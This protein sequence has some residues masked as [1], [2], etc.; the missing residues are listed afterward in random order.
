MPTETTHI[1]LSYPR[2]NVHYTPL[3]EGRL[4]YDGANCNDVG[5]LSQYW[6]RK[7]PRRGRLAQP[8]FMSRK[9]ANESG[10]RC[11]RA[12]DIPIRVGAS[13]MKDIEVQ[14]VCRVEPP[15]YTTVPS[16][17]TSAWNRGAVSWQPERCGSSGSREAARAPGAA[18]PC[19][20]H[21]AG[22]LVLQLL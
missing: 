18:R 5:A 21:P 13:I 14:L 11:K 6:E 17:S 7:A 12:T 9:L 22:A 20:R 16:R 1:N 4:L 15:H 10:Q 2:A 8:T 19:T 3:H